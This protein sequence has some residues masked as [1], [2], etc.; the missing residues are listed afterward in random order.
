MLYI[1]PTH[2]L[3]RRDFFDDSIFDPLLP[4]PGEELPPRV[5]CLVVKMEE[6]ASKQVAD[7]GGDGWKEEHQ[8]ELFVRS[9]G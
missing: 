2:L 6:E 9:E 4:L 3:P 1:Q 8:I 5:G 7:E